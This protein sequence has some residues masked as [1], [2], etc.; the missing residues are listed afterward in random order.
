MS[1]QEAQRLVG[2]DDERRSPGTR[3]ACTGLPILSTEPLTAAER[4]Q[5]DRLARLL[6][7]G[8]ELIDAAI[9]VGRVDQALEALQQVA[10][11]EAVARVAQQL[12]RNR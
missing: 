11:G 6:R 12:G 4:Q 10:V 7:T 8:A 2:Q 1:P 3:S 5:L 9:A